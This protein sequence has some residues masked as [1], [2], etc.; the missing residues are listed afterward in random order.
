MQ[1]LVPQ[2]DE[3]SLTYIVICFLLSYLQSRCVSR[4]GLAMYQI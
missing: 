1:I 4:S 3:L 2:N